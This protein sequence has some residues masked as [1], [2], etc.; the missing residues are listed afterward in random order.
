METTTIQISK[1][2]KKK[3]DSLKEHKSVSYQEVLDK[4][5]AQQKQLQVRE[6]LKEYFTK[7]GKEHRKE[8]N[9]W[10]DDEWK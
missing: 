10:R 9:E 5:L 6:D 1:A 2:M 4:I 3:L 8:V 7:Y